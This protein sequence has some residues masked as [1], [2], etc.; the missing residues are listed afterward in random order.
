MIT[1]NNKTYAE[2]RRLTRKYKPQEA[3]ALVFQNGKHIVDMPA[4]SRSV[5]HF[6]NISPKW[7][8]QQMDKFGTPDAIFH[9]HPCAAVPSMTDEAYMKRVGVIW[10]NIIWLIMSDKMQIRAWKYNIQNKK[11]EEVNIQ[12]V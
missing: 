2:L 7:I 12:N 1:I 10:R 4:G 6:S 8:A 5:G 9:S 11:I 3:C